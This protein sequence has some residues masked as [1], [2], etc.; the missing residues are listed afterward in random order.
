MYGVKII[1][2]LSKFYFMLV[3][4]T[5]ICDLGELEINWTAYF[6]RPN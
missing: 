4:L 6:S 5:D 3:Y 2:D 1:F